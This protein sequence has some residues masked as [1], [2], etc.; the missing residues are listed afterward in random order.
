[1]LTLGEGY[2]NFHHEFPNDYRNGIKWYHYDPT[3]WLIRAFE[4]AGLAFKVSRS[5]MKVIERNYLRTHTE[6]HEAEIVKLQQQLK[7][8]DVEVAG[9][10][11]IPAWSMDEVKRRCTT[12]AKLI[13]IDGAVYDMMKSIPSGVGYTHKNQQIN[14]YT[15]HPGGEKLLDMFVGKDASVAFHGNV[16]KHSLAANNLLNHLRVATVA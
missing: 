2:H 12:G 8:M 6:T 15:S 14:W 16:Y 11:A 9:S 13:V 5:P 7:T 4:Y 10:A 1:V 3:K